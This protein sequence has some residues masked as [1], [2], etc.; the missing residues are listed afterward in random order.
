MSP[1]AIAILWG[2]LEIMDFFI[3]LPEIGI[4]AKDEL[5]RTALHYSCETDFK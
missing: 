5:G 3:N 2:N 1:L 4:N